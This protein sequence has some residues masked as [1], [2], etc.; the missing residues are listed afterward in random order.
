MINI[1]K[2]FK[3]I[4]ENKE[5]SEEIKALKSHNATLSDEVQNQGIKIDELEAK[6]EEFRKLDDATP[7]DCKRGRWCSSCKFRREMFEKIGCNWRT[8]YF[9]GKAKSCSNFVQEEH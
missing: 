7:N 6:L 1:F 4:K 3:L 2:L 5:L 9:C 8:V